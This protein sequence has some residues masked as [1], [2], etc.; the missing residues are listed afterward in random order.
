MQIDSDGER[1]GDSQDY[2][3][4]SGSYVLDPLPVQHLH[5]LHRR[6]QGYAMETQDRSNNRY[7]NSKL[8]KRGK[9]VTFFRNGDPHFKG[10]P[11]SVSGK[12]FASFETLMIFLNEKISTTAGVR[13]ILSLPEG[14][15]IT[16]ITDFNTG[17]YYVVSSVKKLNR[18]VI[19]GNS[20][21]TY[22]IN[23][24][25]SAGKFRKGEAKL[26]VNNS[27]KFSKSA[28]GSMVSS[29]QLPNSRI[30]EIISNTN[31]DSVERV[32]LNTQTTQ[33]FEE[34]LSDIT[35]MIVLQHPPVTTLYTARPPFKRVSLSLKE[36]YVQFQLTVK[37][38]D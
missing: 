34:I 4:E 31:R 36:K 11:V 6:R 9:L 17:H 13:H 26:L 37:M 10:L 33:S 20:R 23:K 35:G 15:E 7:A 25:F 29:P 14:K 27:D 32:I 38:D 21:E 28:P 30:L 24:N 16:D 19:Y 8:Q 22:W 5:L 1:Y 12:N 18:N 2:D 3:N